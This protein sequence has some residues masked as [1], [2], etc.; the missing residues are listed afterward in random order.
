MSQ[1]GFAPHQFSVN[2]V[3]SPGTVMTT[4]VFTFFQKALVFPLELSNVRDVKLS[5]VNNWMPFCPLMF[6]SIQVIFSFVLEGEK[7]VWYS[8]LRTKDNNTKTTKKNSSKTCK[9]LST[10]RWKY[11]NAWRCVLFHACAN[12]YETKAVANMKLYSSCKHEKAFW[13]HDYNLV[14]F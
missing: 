8:F 3:Y 12:I 5:Q 11:D 4:E 7:N 1:Q 2:F 14:S 10:L 6:W 9:L 13:E